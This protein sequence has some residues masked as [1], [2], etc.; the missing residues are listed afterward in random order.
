MKQ[1]LI[2]AD[3]HGSF[4]TWMTIRELLAA[5]DGLA[6]AGDLFDTRYGNYGSQDFV[7]DFIKKD[8]DGFPHPFY[9]VYGNC[10]VGAFFP[11]Y[12]KEKIFDAFGKTIF[13]HHGH[14]RPAVP[15][16]ADIVIQ[17]H[18]H[19]CMLEEQNG[20]IY[21]NPGSMTCPRNG[22]PSY[23]YMDESGLFLKALQTGDLLTSIP[24]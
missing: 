23:A 6:V 22:L 11:G 4:N 10:D 13:L 20:R 18:T 14:G 19:L 21:L 12:K 2:T 15:T 8:L 24:F 5:G 3:V 7:P 9:Y 16:G 17:G 1:L